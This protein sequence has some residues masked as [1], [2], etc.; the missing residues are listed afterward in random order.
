MMA[1]S[2]EDRV[3]LTAAGKADVMRRSERRV[4]EGLSCCCW[5]WPFWSGDAGVFD[6]LV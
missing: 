6:T 2:S 3:H 5:R 4:G 1:L